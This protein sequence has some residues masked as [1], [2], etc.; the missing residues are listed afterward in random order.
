MIIWGA[1]YVG[2]VDQV[3]GLF[4]LQTR[5]T[6]V[7][8]VPVFPEQRGCYLVVE[9]K[10]LARRAPE[11]P[12]AQTAIGGETLFPDESFRGYLMARSWK[13]VGF[14]Y[15]RGVLGFLAAWCAFGSVILANDPNGRGQQVWWKGATVAAVS[16]VLLTGTYWLSRASR[17]KASMLAATVGIPEDEVARAFGERSRPRFGP[18]ETSR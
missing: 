12:G 13:S 8:L 2:K 18:T 17:A 16:V 6:H 15:L 5:F 10:E 3:P 9:D 11:H 7:F 4:Y 1:H 14:G